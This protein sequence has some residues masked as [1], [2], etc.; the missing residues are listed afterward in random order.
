M[1]LSN[2]GVLPASLFKQTRKPLRK[3]SQQLSNNNDNINNNKDNFNTPSKNKSNS[4]GN[5]N[6]KNSLKKMLNTGKSVNVQD[7]KTAKL[8]LRES[9]T[10]SSSK[11]MRPKG[12]T[13]PKGDLQSVLQKQLGDMR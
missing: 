6:N 4:N 13:P 5:N 12:T 1:F 11:W 9:A 8:N 7:L 2:D 3:I 10:S